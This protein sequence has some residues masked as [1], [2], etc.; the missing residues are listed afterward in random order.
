M[1]LA[2]GITAY[3]FIGFIVAIYC[4]RVEP[5]DDFDPHPIYPIMVAILW[6]PF[7]LLIAAECAAYALMQ[8]SRRTPRQRG[9]R[10]DA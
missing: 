2:L 6:L 10:L 7:G 3:I 1:Y 4:W 5:S 9:G 8:L